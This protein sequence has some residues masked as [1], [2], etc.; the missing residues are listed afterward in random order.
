VRLACYDAIAL[1]AAGPGGAA[2]AASAAGPSLSSAPPAARFGLPAAPEPVERIESHI[3]G[4]FEGWRAGERIRLANG[5][6]WQVADDSSAAYW[7]DSPKV[8]VR[9]GALGSYWL[10]VEG[11]RRSVRVRRLE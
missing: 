9:R 5:Q 8:V 11:A 4:R 7:L 1:G 6:L 2:S 10:D 3:A